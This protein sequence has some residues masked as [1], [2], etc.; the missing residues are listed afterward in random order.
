MSQARDTDRHRMRGSAYRVE[1]G[2]M[3]AEGANDSHAEQRAPSPPHWGLEFHYLPAIVA[4]YR[5][6][7]VGGVR[8]DR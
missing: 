3:H 1:S 4:H 5:E 7:E 8:D 2:G 6:L